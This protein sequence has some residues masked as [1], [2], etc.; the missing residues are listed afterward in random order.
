MWWPLGLA[1][2]VG[3]LLTL[4]SYVLHV[5]ELRQQ[6]RREGGYLSR[7]G[8]I[9]QPE[10]GWVFVAV[11]FWPAL[12]F[13]WI[14]WKLIFPK[15]VKSRSIKRAEAEDRREAE[16]KERE[17]AQARFEEN[18]HRAEQLLKNWAPRA[19]GPGTPPITADEVLAYELAAASF[20]GACEQVWRDR[21][22]PWRIGALEHV[23]ARVRAAVK[24]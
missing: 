15:G 1:Y 22:K 2:Y 17:E 9:K 23:R 20:N 8:W 19:I 24:P 5:E 16:R 14:S 7:R 18:L 11:P 21:G 12:A 13:G 3:A 6:R 4:R 10:A